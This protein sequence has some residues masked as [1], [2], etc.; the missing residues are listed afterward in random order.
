MRRTA[1]AGLGALLAACA[2]APA[3]SGHPCDVYRVNT[4]Y[5]EVN[6]LP[7]VVAV[8]DTVT[9]QVRVTRP[10]DEDPAYQG[11]DLPRPVIQPAEGVNVSTSGYAQDADGTAYAFLGSYTQTDGFGQAKLK[12]H[13]P[14]YVPVGARVTVP[15][16]AEKL[17]ADAP[18]ARVFE[19]KLKVLPNA[20]RVGSR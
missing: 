5:L 18:C 20:F 11:I 12:L 14:R 9:I 6:P 15:I 7:K 1:L 13:V 17:I 10:S 3:A 16:Q 8:G 19:W 2:A 4:L